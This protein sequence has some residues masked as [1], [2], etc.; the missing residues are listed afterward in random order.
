MD[1]PILF[2]LS[3]I[4]FIIDLSQPTIHILNQVWKYFPIMKV[5]RNGQKLATQVYIICPINEHNCPCYIVKGGGRV[6]LKPKLKAKGTQLKKK[7]LSR[8][9]NLVQQLL[10]RVITWNCEK[11]RQNRCFRRKSLFP[12]D[13]KVSHQPSLF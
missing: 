2:I 8:H 1:V 5:S 9:C 7:I 3:Q 12:P 6:F 4:Y 11:R 13:L 10:Y